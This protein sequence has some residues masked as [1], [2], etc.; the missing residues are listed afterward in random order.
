MTR[1]AVRRVA[2]AAGLAGLLGLAGC[3][4][5]TTPTSVDATMIPTA[6]A[7]ATTTAAADPHVYVDMSILTGKMVGKP[8]WPSYVPADFTVPAHATVTVTIRDFDNGP[9]PVPAA[10][11]K[12]QGTVGGTMQVTSGVLGDV[13]ALP[14]TTVNSVAANDVAHT[15]T[16]AGLNLNVPVPPSST[17]TFT[18]QTGAPGTYTWQCFAPCGTGTT[19]WSGPMADAGY[20]Q[21][22]ITVQ[23]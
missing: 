1:T 11:L 14:A 16:A 8:G 18:F 5:I 7:A 19:G 6:A 9:A 13:A 17:V 2:A 20:M 23:A 3:G 10:N 22:T 4:Q 15:F 21:G 12:V